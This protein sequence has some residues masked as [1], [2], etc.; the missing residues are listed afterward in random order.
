[1]TKIKILT[2]VFAFALVLAP[3]VALP[4]SSGCADCAYDSTTDE[5]ACVSDGSYWANCSGGR[6]CEPDAYGHIHCYAACFG[7]RCLWT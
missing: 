6:Y 7:Q 3:A 1:M 5:T 2:F 4:M